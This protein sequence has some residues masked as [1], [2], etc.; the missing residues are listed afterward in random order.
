MA[1]L[2]LQA[3]G[4]HENHGFQRFSGG[5]YIL[6]I[7]LA[8]ARQPTG[9]QHAGLRSNILARDFNAFFYGAH[10]VTGVETDIPPSADQCLQFF[11]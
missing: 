5:C 1:L 9:F 3:L 2:L 6:L 7:A 11:L 10:T 8:I 4:L